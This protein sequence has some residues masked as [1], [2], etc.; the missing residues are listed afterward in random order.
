M[1]QIGFLKN[2]YINTGRGNALVARLL[3]KL[4]RAVADMRRSAFLHSWKFEQ[5]R[6]IPILRARWLPTANRRESAG[7]LMHVMALAWSTEVR[8]GC[9]D[10]AD[11]QVGRTTPIQRGPTRVLGSQSIADLAIWLFYLRDAGP[12]CRTLRRDSP[13]VFTG[14]S[15][16]RA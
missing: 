14:R 7:R 15:A 2:Q 8:M 6:F 9:G 13:T 4:D 10:A 5:R 3:G 11:A 16:I 1:A 12:I